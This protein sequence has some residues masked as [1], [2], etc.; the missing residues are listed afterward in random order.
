MCGNFVEEITLPDSLQVIGS[1]AF[2]TAA[3]C[4]GSVWE[5]ET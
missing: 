1:C 3:G 2:T 5:P 4:G